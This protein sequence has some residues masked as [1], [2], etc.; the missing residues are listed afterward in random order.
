MIRHKW[1]RSGVLTLAITFFLIGVIFIVADAASADGAS[2]DTIVALGKAIFFDTRLSVPSGE[3]CS[4]CHDPATGF[5]DPRNNLPVSTGAIKYRVGDRNA[6]S[7]TYAMY[8]PPLFYDSTMRPGIMGGN[9]W[10]V[11]SGTAGLT[12]SK[13]RR[14]CRS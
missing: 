13:N 12:C 11:Y 6:P 2:S 4:T 9:T 3:A 1:L 5:A 14:N 7:I 8:S 10:V